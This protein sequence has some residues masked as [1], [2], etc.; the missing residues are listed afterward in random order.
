[1]A[2]NLAASKRIM[3]LG[4]NSQINVFTEPQHRIGTSH[5]W[6]EN[7]SNPYKR[8]Y[9]CQMDSRSDGLRVHF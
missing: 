5:I 3:D 2:L 4:E 9:Y 7:K 8:N 1:M 6:L